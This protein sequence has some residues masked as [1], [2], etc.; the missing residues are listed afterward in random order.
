MLTQKKDE[1]LYFQAELP[2]HCDRKEA[3]DIN[4]F[5]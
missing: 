1:F 5:G 3:K 2:N 4:I